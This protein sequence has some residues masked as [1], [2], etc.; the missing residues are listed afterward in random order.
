VTALADLAAEL[1]LGPEVVDEAR[2]D[3]AA[4]ADLFAWG[5]GSAASAGQNRGV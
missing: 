4:W 1:A 5:N 3:A 2:A